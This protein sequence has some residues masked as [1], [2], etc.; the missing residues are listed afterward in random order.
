MGIKYKQQYDGEWVQPRRKDYYMKCCDC[1]LV[2]KIDFRL[3][4]DKYKK[5]QFRAF[6][7]RRRKQK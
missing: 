2:H 3:V 6:R 5:I 1:G 4:G 7:I